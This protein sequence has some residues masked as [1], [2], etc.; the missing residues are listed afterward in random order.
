LNQANWKIIIHKT[1]NKLLQIRNWN[2]TACQIQTMNK[3]N[4]KGKY[5]KYNKS[6][7]KPKINI[8]T[9]QNLVYYYTHTTEEV[10]TALSNTKRK[11]GKKWN[12][13][14]MDGVVSSVGKIL[15]QCG[16]GNTIST[17]NN[18]RLD[19]RQSSNMDSRN[20]TTDNNAWTFIVHKLNCV[21]KQ[22]QPTGQAPSYLKN[23]K[24]C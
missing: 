9:P 12:S 5:K 10:I 23:G 21:I 22:Q 8:R 4:N 6:I 3:E 18:T 15:L 17:T 1:I 2:I 24:Y 11:C 16:I 7:K 14:Q 13:N 20:G 19:K